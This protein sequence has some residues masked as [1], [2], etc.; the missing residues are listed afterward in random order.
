MIERE[1]LD[2]PHFGPL[3]YIGVFAFVLAKFIY[4]DVIYKFNSIHKQR[5]NVHVCIRIILH[6]IRNNIPSILFCV[7]YTI[8]SIESWIF[9][10]HVAVRVCIYILSIYSGHQLYIFW[11]ANSNT[12]CD[13]MVALSNGPTFVIRWAVSAHQFQRRII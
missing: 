2:T 12:K 5:K 9:S 7:I 4:F 11:E 13:E 10:Q 1:S 8:F 3:F 6:L